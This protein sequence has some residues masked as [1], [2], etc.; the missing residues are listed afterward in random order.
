[1]PEPSMKNLK[2][3]GI[4]RIKNFR[5]R[6]KTVCELMRYWDRLSPEEGFPRWWPKRKGKTMSPADILY[7]A[8]GATP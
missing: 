4:E 8:L 6:Y 1:M 2:P 7:E 3:K 5:G